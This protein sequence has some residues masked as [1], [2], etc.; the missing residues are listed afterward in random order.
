MA[1]VRGCRRR[2]WFFAVV[3]PLAA[4]SDDRPAHVICCRGVVLPH[5]QCGRPY[6]DHLPVSAGQESKGSSAGSSGGWGLICG[7]TGEGH[8]SELLAGQ[9]RS[10]P[11][12]HGAQGFAG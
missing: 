3:M 11:C 12:G 5:T 8:A 1:D 9:Q 7:S 6:Y 4:Q 10:V 2:C